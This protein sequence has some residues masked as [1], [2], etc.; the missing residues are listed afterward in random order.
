M[1]KI[2]FA[3]VILAAILF[4]TACG[5]PASNSPTNQPD[6]PFAQELQ[7]ALEN[8]LEQYGG[9]GISAAVIV[10]SYEMWS[11]VSGVSHGS[12]PIKTDTLSAQAAS[13]RCIRQ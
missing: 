13:T 12:V 9:M 3:L 4:V 6:L 5:T 8:G 11:G 7:Q 2:K 10:P 1:K